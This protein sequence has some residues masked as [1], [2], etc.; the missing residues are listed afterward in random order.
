MLGDEFFPLPDTNFFCATRNYETDPGSRRLIGPLLS[1]MAAESEM[2]RP[3]KAEMQRLARNTDVHRN[4]FNVEGCLDLGE[5]LEIRKYI[6]QMVATMPEAVQGYLCDLV[7]ATDTRSP[8]EFKK[9][10]FKLQEPNGSKTLRKLRFGQKRLTAD[11]LK[12][13]PETNLRSLEVMVRGVSMR[14][15]IWQL[16]LACALAFMNGRDKADFCD[17]EQAWCAQTHQLL[18]RPVARSYGI[19]SMHILTT[20]LDSVRY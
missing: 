4:I 11:E 1:R 7:I 13:L 10:D 5:V 14:S 16:H 20:A 15:F 8:E 3:S 6:T 12:V 2:F 19:D 9:L 18:M 17:I